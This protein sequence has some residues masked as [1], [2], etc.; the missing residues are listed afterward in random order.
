MLQNIYW[1]KYIEF[2][3]DSKVELHALS[4]HFL[5]F[6]LKKGRNSQKFP[7]LVHDLQIMDDLLKFTEDEKP[8]KQHSL[9]SLHC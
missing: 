3:Q 8:R 4:L 6:C 7:I 5:K 1:L 9:Q 2:S